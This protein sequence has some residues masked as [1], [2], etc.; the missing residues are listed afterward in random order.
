[1]E[2]EIVKQHPRE[3]DVLFLDLLETLVEE[4]EEDTEKYKYAPFLAGSVVEHIAYTED[5]RTPRRIICILL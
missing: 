3:N 2:I 4:K 1:M 5:T